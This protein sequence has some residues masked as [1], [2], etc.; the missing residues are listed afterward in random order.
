MPELENRL[1]RPD[2]HRRAQVRTVPGGDD[3]TRIPDRQLVARLQGRG[4][5]DLRRTPA[6]RDARTPEIRQT[7]HHADHQGGTGVA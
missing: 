6:R 7:D 3:R 2:G 5:F 1:S 4:T